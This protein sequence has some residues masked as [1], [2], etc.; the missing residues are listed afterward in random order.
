[1][2]VAPPTTARVDAI[3]IRVMACSR[4]KFSGRDFVQLYITGI[5]ER[6]AIALAGFQER[7]SL[8]WTARFHA[9]DDLRWSG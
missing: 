4:P 6:A 7:L 3:T 1:M 9:H 2:L 8:F 5:A